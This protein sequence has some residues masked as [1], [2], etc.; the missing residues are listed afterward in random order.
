MNE[1]LSRK[2]AANRLGISTRTLDSYRSQGLLA[3]IQLSPNGRVMIRA[4]AIE[5]F[6]ARG[7]HPVAPIVNRPTYRKR[8]A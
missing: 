5:A 1:L 3:Y 7:N 4:D 2:E 6:L 8:R